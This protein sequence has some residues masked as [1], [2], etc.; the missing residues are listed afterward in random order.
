MLV[1]ARRFSVRDVLSRGNNPFFACA[2]RVP[3]ADAGAVATEDARRRGRSRGRAVR[4]VG[5]TKMG[6][7]LGTYTG[8]LLR[9]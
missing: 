2:L 9:D 8:A 3:L 1:Q 5:S 7:V 6:S 4:C